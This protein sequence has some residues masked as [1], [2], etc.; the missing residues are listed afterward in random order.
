VAAAPRRW[1]GQNPPFDLSKPQARG[2]GHRPDR[3]TDEPNGDLS[4][5]EGLALDGGCIRGIVTV[6][7]MQR[8]SA[9]AGLEDWLDS[10]D[11]K[12]PEMID[13]AERVDIRPAA[14]F[15]RTAW[16]GVR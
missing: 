9:E 16:V 10:A 15:L 3:P 6:V 2:E 5:G 12:V 11:H 4:G 8:L 1:R 14:R 13:F 7:L